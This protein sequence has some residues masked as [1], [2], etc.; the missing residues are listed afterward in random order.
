MTKRKTH[1]ELMEGGRRLGMVRAAMIA[2]GHAKIYRDQ[3]T[4]QGLLVAT[5]LSS[6]AAFILQEARFDSVPRGDGTYDY[7]AWETRETDA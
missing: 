3:G 4:D 7:V 1:A 6:A 5:A 2:D